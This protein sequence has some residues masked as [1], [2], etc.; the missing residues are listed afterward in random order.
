MGVLFAD[1]PMEDVSLLS[2]ELES[3]FERGGRISLMVMLVFLVLFC[4]ILWVAVKASRQYSRNKR[5]AEIQQLNSEIERLRALNRK[6]TE[7]NL[8]LSKMARDSQFFG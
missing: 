1:V 7:R 8:E 5:E 2:M 3:D 4:F 6:L